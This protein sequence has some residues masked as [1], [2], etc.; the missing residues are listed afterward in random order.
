MAT[1]KTISHANDFF[2]IPVGMNT[3]SVSLNISGTY[4]GLLTIK[5]YVAATGTG[6][7]LELFDENN[8]TSVLNA[9]DQK[10]VFFDVGG[11]QFV[12]ILPASWT[13]GSVKLIAVISNQTR[14]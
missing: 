13:S 14:N 9:G 4:S 6:Y 8:N 3:G 2:K 7:D 10:D 12:N 5:G 1:S 11:L